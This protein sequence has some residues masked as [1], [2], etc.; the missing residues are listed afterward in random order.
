MLENSMPISLGLNVFTKTGTAA[1]GAVKGAVS[2]SVSCFNRCREPATSLPKCGGAIPT[3][4][5]VWSANKDSLFRNVFQLDLRL[6]V[7]I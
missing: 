2:G 1:H 3:N 4:Q 5:Q 6:P 7:G